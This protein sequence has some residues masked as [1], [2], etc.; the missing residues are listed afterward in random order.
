MRKA[1][2]PPPPAFFDKI[3][4]RLPPPLTLSITL[5]QIFLFFFLCWFPQLPT[6]SHIPPLLIARSKRRSFS[7]LMR[8]ALP[9]TGDPPQSFYLNLLPLGLKQLGFCKHDFLLFCGPRVF[10]PV[11]YVSSD[12]AFL[13]SYTEHTLCFSSWGLSPF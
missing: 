10:S 7:S 11:P 4:M 6:Y 13:F 12:S 2:R 9:I 8:S 3:L 1:C 5:M